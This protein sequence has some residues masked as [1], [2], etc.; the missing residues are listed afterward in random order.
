MSRQRLGFL[1]RNLIRIFLLTIC[2]SIVTFALM[3]ASPIDPLQANVGQAALGSM[4]QE[5]KEK[6][7]KY[8][9][10]DT[11]PAEQYLSW[12]KDFF[13]GDM[14]TSLLFR[15]PVSKVIAVKLS[16]SLFLMI[17]A[18]ILSGMLG[19]LLGVVSGMNR[20]KLQIK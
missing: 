17:M 10:V 4:S 7:E 14:G 1:V 19:F 16:N 2:I 9:G 3:K 6:L 8:W 12:V 20:G 13:R 18:W 15:Q 5:Q 11:P